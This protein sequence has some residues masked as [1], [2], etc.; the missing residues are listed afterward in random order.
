MHVIRLILSA[1]SETERNKW[2]N[3]LNDRSGGSTKAS[4]LTGM[5]IF[6]LDSFQNFK[7]IRQT[8]LKVKQAIQVNQK[9]L[10]E[11]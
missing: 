6:R 11:R 1:N 10:K 7:F 5:N 4:Q 8:N 2:I 3:I 9:N